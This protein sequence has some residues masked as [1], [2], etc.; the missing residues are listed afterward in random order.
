[1]DGAVSPLTQALC[2]ITETLS[3]KVVQVYRDEKLMYEKHQTQGL[4]Y[5]GIKL[6]FLWIFL[7]AMDKD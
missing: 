1:L 4:V 2:S 5:E 6:F 3:S 7:F